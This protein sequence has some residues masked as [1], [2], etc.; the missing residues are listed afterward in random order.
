MVIGDS[1][2]EVLIF[3]DRQTDKHF[4][5]IYISII[6]NGWILTLTDSMMLAT[7]TSMMNMNDIHLGGV[8]LYEVSIFAEL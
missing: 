3:R 6:I 4:I 8:G 5:I 2:D 7:M 1:Q